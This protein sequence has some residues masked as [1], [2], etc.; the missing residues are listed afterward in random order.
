M[1]CLAALQQQQQ[2]LAGLAV[3]QE[4]LQQRLQRCSSSWT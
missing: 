1:A 3:R 2:A 4:A